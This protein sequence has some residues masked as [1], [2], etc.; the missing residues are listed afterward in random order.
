VY[1]AVGGLPALAFREDLAFV[2]RV[3][4]AGYHMRHALDVR[5]R[6]SARLEGRA[7]GG[8]ADCLKDWVE[9]E[10]AGRPHLVEKPAA[11]AARLRM[12]RMI[13]TLNWSAPDFGRRGCDLSRALRSSHCFGSGSIST[14]ALIETLVP[15]EP[16][17]MA[18]MP[19]EVA[20]ADIT[21]MIA[22][23]H[24]TRVD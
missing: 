5:V 7:P 14:P 15:D 12:R 2:S 24:E 4:A 17:A 18:S 13:R 11:V 9:A 23:A 10:A 21:R 22:D 16:D 1:A 8:M 19:I 20:V 3:R 6:V